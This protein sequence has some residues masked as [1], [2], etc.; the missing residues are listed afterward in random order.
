MT[1]IKR[2]FCERHPTAAE[3]K[4]LGAL[5]DEVGPPE[6]LRLIGQYV[7]H[8]HPD[9]LKGDEIRGSLARL[10]KAIHDTEAKPS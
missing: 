6:L 9:L 3:R 8:E 7:A 1:R 10:A 4:I 5:L 2:H